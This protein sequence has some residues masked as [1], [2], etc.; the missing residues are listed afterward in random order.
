[1]N[2]ISGRVILK[3]T[4]G[5]IPVGI[6][7]LLVVIYDVDPGTTPEEAIST[8]EAGTGGG[9]REG[10]LGRHL[11]LSLWHL[12]PAIGIWTS[13]TGWV[14][15]LRVPTVLSGS[16]MRMRSF[17]FAILRRSVLICC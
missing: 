3:E 1:M 6:P 14:P 11:P 9:G 12:P 8:G 2:Y 7:D 17:R 13:E 4:S 16:S 15:G 5:G 10:G